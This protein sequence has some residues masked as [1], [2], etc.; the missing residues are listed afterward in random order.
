VCSSDLAKLLC[1]DDN[2][3]NR[4]TLQ[5]LLMPFGFDLTLVE[6]GEAAVQAAR[7]AS[8]DSV[9]LDIHMPGMDG[10]ETLRALRKLPGT[11]QARILAMTAD[12]MPEAVLRYESA[13]FQGVVAKP[14]I[15]KDLLGALAPAA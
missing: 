15:I 2:L 3:V 11:S 12:V 5:A 14:L 1:V 8:F 7:G 13:G 6:S 9:L 4:R 10:F